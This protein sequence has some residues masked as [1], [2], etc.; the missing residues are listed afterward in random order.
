MDME[1]NLRKNL[2]G[3]VQAFLGHPY[4]ECFTPE[5]GLYLSNI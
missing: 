2:Q 3:R 4:L 5:E 1:E